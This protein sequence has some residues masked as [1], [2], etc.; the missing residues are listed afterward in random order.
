[1]DYGITDLMKMDS[2]ESS[3]VIWQEVHLFCKQLLEDALSCYP[4]TFTS[5]NFALSQTIFRQ[6]LVTL[7]LCKNWSALLLI[8]WL[9]VVFLLAMYVRA[10]N[11]RD[12]KTEIWRHR[13]W[14][15]RIEQFIPETRFVILGYIWQTDNWGKHAELKTWNTGNF[16]GCI[17]F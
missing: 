13:S 17:D 8:M 6:K 1:M 11:I 15:V 2:S 12:I 10:V 7:M 5:Q 9:P 16:I 3:H 14:F 4:Q